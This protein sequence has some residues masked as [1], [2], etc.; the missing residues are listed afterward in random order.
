MKKHITCTMELNF[1]MH[2]LCCTLNHVFNVC[3]HR[4]TEYTAPCTCRLWMRTENICH[5]VCKQGVTQQQHM[6]SI[7]IGQLL[8]NKTQ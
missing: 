7:S 5:K 4:H 6:G 8:K 2:K 3:T 1:V